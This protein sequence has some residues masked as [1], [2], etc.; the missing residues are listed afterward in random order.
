[1]TYQ[2]FCQV[3][4]A[5][6]WK[7]TSK[8]PAGVGMR[9]DA[10][11]RA[12]AATVNALP[13]NADTP[14]SV[15]RSHADATATRWGY[16]WQLGHPIEPAHLWFH[17]ESP[18]AS[19]VPLQGDTQT[20][21]SGQF[22][23]AKASTFSN[24]TS[25][26]GYGSYSNSVANS[27]G[28]AYIDS[29]ITGASSIGAILL[30]AQDT[31]PGREFFC[32]ALKTTG[33]NDEL[34]RDCCHALFKS[35]GTTGWC[36]LAV[37][38]R[39]SRQ[40]YETVALHGYSGNRFGSLPSALSTSLHSNGH[41]LRSGIAIG[42]YDFTLE[43]QGLLDSPPPL[44]QLPAPLFIGS[45]TIRGAST[46][47]GKV[48]RSDGVMLQLGQRSLAHDIWLWLPSGTSHSQAS[49]WMS[50]FALSYWRECNELHFISGLPPGGL[51]PVGLQLVTGTADFIR[52][53]PPMSAAG[54]RQHPQQGPLLSS[55]GGGGDGGDGSG[56]LARPT[57]GLLWPRGV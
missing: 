45:T 2:V 3:F 10:A 23:S 48:T 21:S 5:G 36:S 53:F 25:N 49:P 9:L 55:P 38:P 11:F 33:G 12:F 16:T 7:W 50:V 39:T 26:G 47:F 24:N 43:S 15:I 22:G 44:I 31:T 28:L 54:T 13:G 17:V 18:T 4:P 8:D 34:H 41:Q 42:H 35:P 29:T 37:F 32:W 20:Y 57:S 30:I 56:A 46:H 51:P 19:G 40:P 1:M 6:S 14:L 27:A 52:N